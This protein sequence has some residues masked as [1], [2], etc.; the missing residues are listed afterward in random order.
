M[1]IVSEPINIAAAQG[2]KGFRR[3]NPSEVQRGSP[4]GGE[5]RRTRD[6]RDKGRE[7]EI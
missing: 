6:T 3:A 7:Q 5:P 2:Q 1:L 4:D